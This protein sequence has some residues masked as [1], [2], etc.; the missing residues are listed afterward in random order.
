MNQKFTVCPGAAQIL[1][2]AIRDDVERSSTIDLLL[3]LNQT[4]IIVT[5]YRETLFSRAI[6]RRDS[7]LSRQ[8]VS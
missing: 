7:L 2:T 6:V 4:A 8:I 3:L 1:R 5:D